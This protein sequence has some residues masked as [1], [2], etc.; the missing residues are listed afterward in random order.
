M[1]KG[2]SLINSPNKKPLFFIV[3]LGAG[4][5]GSYILQ[6]NAQLCSIFEQESF[7]LICDPDHVEKKNLRN[8][9]FI[10]RDLGK[11]KAEVL[12]DRYGRHYDVNMASYTQSFV[13]S[14]ETLSRLFDQIKS[15]DHQNRPI[16]PILIGCVDNNFTRQIMHEFFVTQPDLL[17]IDVGV[18]AAQTPDD[19]NRQDKSRWTKDE[20][21][22]YS[23]SGW[24]G[25][26]VAGLRM[27]G[28]T[29]LEPVAGLYP[30]ILEDNDDI[31]PSE[32]SC[33]QIVASDP[34]RLATNKLA[35]MAVY[36]FM[37]EILES[38]SLSMHQAIFHARKGYLRSTPVPELVMS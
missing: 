30:D 29:L 8:Q 34:Q 14:S 26:V 38:K 6:Q 15:F 37:N 17:Y 21:D 25:Q 3:Q 4:G 1:S 20:L 18:E 24:T 33:Q 27:N 12:T 36:T 32:I 9:L 28:E 22:A 10:E 23:N 7:H 31:A 19:L 16:I 5:N 13:E 11:M 35:S 2:I